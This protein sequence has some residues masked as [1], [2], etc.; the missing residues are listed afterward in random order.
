MNLNRSKIRD[1]IITMYNS[2][3]FIWLILLSGVIVRLRQYLYNRS[4]WLD[5]ASLALN[6]I[7]RD[8]SG[9]FKPLAYGQAAPP[10]FMVL[11]E[12]VTDIFNSNSEF[13]LRL[14]P[15]IC[16]LLSLFLFYILAKKF[17]NRGIPLALIL[18]SFSKYTI[19][20]S[21]EFKQYASDM[22]ATIIIL[23]IS[24]YT[25]RVNFNKKGCA[26]LAVIGMLIPWFSHTSVFMLAGSGITLFLLVIF[27][28]DKGRNVRV[29]RIIVVGLIW[30]FSF[31][32]YY[33][34]L[35]REAASQHFYSYWAEFFAPFPPLSLSDWKWYYEIVMKTIQNPLGFEYAKWL[36]FFTMVIGIFSLWKNKDKIYILLLL[37]PI[38][39]LL[40][41]SMLN[42]YPFSTR[43][44]L[45]IVPIM[46]L[47]ITEGLYF[48]VKFFAKNKAVILSILLILIILISPLRF[49]SRVLFNP[50]QREESRP[51]INYL[52]K[53]YNQSDNIY[54]SYGAVRAFAYYN[55]I[56]KMNYNNIKIIS[57]N[58][59]IIN[60]E[61]YE[62]LVKVIKEKERV[63][64]LFSHIQQKKKDMFIEKL[65]ILGQ[66]IDSYQ[67]Q[68][69]VVYLYSFD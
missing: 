57:K 66:R 50:L 20:Y 37:T 35:I 25:Y 13:F 8:Y 68:G 22:L 51:V 17:L 46:Y 58:D 24:Y 69:A 45:F 59:F 62:R 30:L 15:L 60:S 28:N 52:N 63:W 26:L 61:G 2:H 16:G 39:I 4:L 38:I 55:E 48:I 64:F 47:L 29:I 53:N 12:F 3:L 11:T 44:I 41:A 67:K 14:V 56:N 34:F 10:F 1:F 5:E 65:D 23:L 33:I 19:Y 6:I 43:L 9:F 32:I 40:V 31:L 42:I 18:M 54:L 21:T 27:N 36:I 49:S 7:E